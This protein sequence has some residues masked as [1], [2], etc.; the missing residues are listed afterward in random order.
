MTNI[1]LKALGAA[2]LAAGLFSATAEAATIGQA[3]ASITGL[4]YRLID[5]DLADG[6]TPTL[7]V[8]GELTAVSSAGQIDFFNEFAFNRDGSDVI[9]APVFGESGLL[10]L[11]NNLV[12]GTA[13]TLGSVISTSSSITSESW[14]EAFS[15]STSEPY[16]YNSRAYD[17][18][19][20]LRNAV[21]TE[22]TT[23]AGGL[24]GVRADAGG[25]SLLTING[26]ALLVI[27]GTATLS[28]L[29]DRSTLIDAYANVP[30]DGYYNNYAFGKGQTA[31]NIN[32]MLSTEAY[33]TLPG[34]TNTGGYQGS[35]FILASTVGFTESGATLNDDGWG[36][37][38]NIEDVTGGTGDTQDFQLTFAHLAEGPIDVNFGMFVDSTVKQQFESTST[39]VVTELGDPIEVTPPPVVV[40][41]GI[42]EPGTY[43]LMGLGLVGMSAAVRRA[44]RSAPGA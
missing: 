11:T 7:S 27:E 39:Q 38:T 41:P 42:P 13:A 5:L 37:G 25:T 35:A 17:S 1:T 2:L 19:G 10:F 22:T 20:I 31:S 44:R 4:R 18:E 8:S 21:I 24:Q 40:V 6:I 28:T 9:T 14:N 12:P 36:G 15:Q 29:F 33:T 26:K 43:A 16:S 23:V 3:E 30:S 34:S 32:L